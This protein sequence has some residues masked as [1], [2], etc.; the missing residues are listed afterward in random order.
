MYPLKRLIFFSLFL[1][2][3][4]DSGKA[5]VHPDTPFVFGLNTQLQCNFGSAGKQRPLCLK[6]WQQQLVLKLLRSEKIPF[7]EVLYDQRWTGNKKQPWQCVW[8]WRGRS[9]SVPCCIGADHPRKQDSIQIRLKVHRVNK[10]NAQTPL[11]LFALAPVLAISPLWGQICIIWICIKCFFWQFNIKEKKQHVANVKQFLV[12][13]LLIKIFN[14]FYVIIKFSEFLNFNVF[15]AA[16]RDQQLQRNK[17]LTYIDLPIIHFYVNFTF[18]VELQK[19]NNRSGYSDVLGSRT[20]LLLLRTF[21]WIKNTST[22]D[23]KQHWPHQPAAASLP[24]P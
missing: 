3:L 19:Y 5:C 16:R 23:V 2:P 14:L 9:Y 21:D 11:C 10:C 24:L 17:I 18:S 6:V 8:Q 15:Y 7:L 20:C 12:V 22:L 4:S 13:T 1:R